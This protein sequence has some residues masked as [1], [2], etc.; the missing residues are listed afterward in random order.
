[1]TAPLLET[2][3][4]IPPARPGLV[5]RPRLTE[6]LNAGAAKFPDRRERYAEGKSAF[7]RGIIQRAQTI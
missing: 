6:Q 2:K 3:L 5:P 1:M 7:I 4:Y